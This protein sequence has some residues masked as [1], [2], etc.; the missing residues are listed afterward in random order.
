MPVRALAIDPSQP[1]ILYAGTFPGVYQSRDAGLTWTLR[2]DGLVDIE[3]LALAVDPSNPAVVYAGT[4]EG[5]FKSTDQGTTWSPSSAGLGT[6]QVTGLAIDPFDS[7][8]LFAGTVRGVY[9]SRDSAA[10]WSEANQGL[11]ADLAVFDFAFDPDPN[12]PVCAATGDGA[13]RP[14]GVATLLAFLPGIQ[15]I[16]GPPRGVRLPAFRRSVGGR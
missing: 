1:E 10:S 2:S 9:V 7:Q 6:S 5:V 15:A 14:E 13:Y 12:G 3:V 4:R 11:P 8:R 16:S